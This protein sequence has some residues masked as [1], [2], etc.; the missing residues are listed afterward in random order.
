L[1]RKNE[2]GSKDEPAPMPG[3][4][5]VPIALSLARSSPK[6]LSELVLR[7]SVRVS[8]CSLS[9]K[10]I[11]VPFSSLFR[12]DVKVSTLS[13]E[14]GFVIAEAIETGIDRA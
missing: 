7:E 14:L 6:A 4:S 10:L 1:L 2:V 8:I 3:P 13:L 12:K 5:N 11:A 9:R